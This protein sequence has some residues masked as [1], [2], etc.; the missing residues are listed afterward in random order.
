MVRVGNGQALVGPE[1]LF[2][3]VRPHI[4]SSHPSLRRES[5]PVGRIVTVSAHRVEHLTPGRLSVAVAAGDSNGFSKK[6]DNLQAMTCSSC[7]T[8]SVGFTRRFG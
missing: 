6:L 4:L 2:Q 8:T 7:G 5:V 1:F 3:R